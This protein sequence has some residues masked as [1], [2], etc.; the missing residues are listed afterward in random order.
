MLGG[1]A[2]KICYATLSMGSSMGIMIS[3]FGT[4]PRFAHSPTHPKPWCAL[5]NESEKELLAHSTIV[6]SD[7][8]S[9]IT[10]TSSTHLT[11]FSATGRSQRR[12]FCIS[13]FI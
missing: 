3:Q 8:Q 13:A 5:V 6:K 9:I 11:V 10:K 12:V 2:S 4:H 1:S 7:C